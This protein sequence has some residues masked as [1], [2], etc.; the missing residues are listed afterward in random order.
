MEALVGDLDD[1]EEAAKPEDIVKVAE[2][3]WK[4]QGS[5]SLEEVEEELQVELP[6]DGSETFN[7]FI[8]VASPAG[9]PETAK[10]SAAAAA[11]SISMFWM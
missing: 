1:Q 9:S 11:R 6:H 8:C 5:A 10:A 3:E 4:I 2:R 7:G